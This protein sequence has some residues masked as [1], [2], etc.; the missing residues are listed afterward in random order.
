[1]F[2]FDLPLREWLLEF[3]LDEDKIMT[4][5][6]LLL[7]LFKGGEHYLT[8]KDM[9]IILFSEGGGQLKL[10]G[11]KK[12]M[13]CFEGDDST[14]DGLTVRSSL[15]RSD[16]STSSTSSSSS[17]SSASSASSVSSAVSSTPSEVV[18]RSFKKWPKSAYP[19]E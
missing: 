15:E 13:F 16:S 11:E 3:G 14:E 9:I 7:T 6:A 4:V 18:K 10:V 2:R 8:K 12:I 17:A 19:H 5:F 1:M